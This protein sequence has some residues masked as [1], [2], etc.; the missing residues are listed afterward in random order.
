M[1]DELIGK[2]IAHYRVVEKLGGGGMGVVYKAEDLNL[3]RFVALKFLPADWAQNPQALERF[4]REARAASAL[5]HP[6]I[7]T[8]HEI[9]EYES[10]PFIAMELLEGQTLKRR[11]SAVAAGPR[12]RGDDRRPDIGAHRAPLEL[13]TLLDLAIQIADGLEAAHAKG[14]VH[15]DIKP[16]NIFITTREQAKILDFGLA[17]QTGVGARHGVPLPSRAEENAATIGATASLEPE[18][19]TSPGTAM[20]TVA[21]M[22]PEQARGEELDPRT[23]LFSFGAVLYEMA[24]ARPAFAGNTTAV[25]F[26]AIL[27]SAP[28]S[29]VRLNPEL[30]AKLEEI[31][32]KALE[33]DRRLRYQTASD[34]LADLKRLKR[35]RES[36][37]SAAV[38]AP[39]AAA[40]TATRSASGKWI[41][42]GVIA[43]GLA[44]VGSVLL[45]KHSLAPTL[46]APA[47]SAPTQPAVHTLAVLPFRDLAGAAANESWGIGMAD[48]IISRLAPLQNLAVRPTSS[49]L[50][51]VQAPPD[52]TQVAKDLGVDSILAGTF[53]HN[54][55]VVRVS[56]QLIDPKTQSTRWAGQYDLHG[57]DMLKFQDEVAQK[58]V[59][60]LKVQV[61]EA[62]HASMTSSMTKSPEAY[63]LYLQALYDWNDYL[64]RSRQE[65]LHEGEAALKEAIAKDPSFPQAYAALSRF[66]VIEIANFRPSDGEL[67]AAE[68]AARHALQLDPHSVE[69]LTALGGL[70]GETGKN[71]ESIQ[72][73]RQALSMAPNQEP[74]H[75]LLGYV[76]H[77]AGLDE[78]AEQEYRRCIELNPTALQ[79]HWMH[80]RMLLYLRRTPEAEQELRQVLSRNPDQFKAMAY[81]GE[82][83]YYEGKTRE[84]EPILARA[85]ELAKGT[86][87]GTAPT[88]AAFVYASQGRRDKIDPQILALR[89][90]QTVDGDGAYWGAGIYTLL[91]EKEQALTWLRRAVELGNHNYP[92]FQRDRNFDKLR[93]DR[94]Y[95]RIMEEVRQRWEHYRELFPPQSF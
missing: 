48:A 61:S 4:R 44:L 30:P 24:T 66:Y 80:A 67:A 5:N 91:G 36:G 16:A 93:G 42:I 77:Y 11:L 39:P 63:N 60:G 22:S 32:N 62:E 68:E 19:L 58:V 47:T 84:A 86:G 34:L 3:G 92:W 14:I 87:D 51:Y 74:I 54:G 23:D 46:P 28:V 26:D 64:M 55:S 76:Y 43:F 53:Q 70:Y 35:D 59:E 94:E 69:A 65:I 79:P 29:P 17:K 90:S 6:N 10:R 73:L 45:Y 71:V 31:V 85:V 88:L 40:A 27:N 89:P 95:Q 25:I 75:N 78:Q 41:V 81:L 2:T 7:C 56:V 18:H 21:Y 33:K 9:N 12:F 1:P 38:T 72:T 57:D 83:L 49:V 13:D 20:G 15:R 8:I 37:R 50:K 82:I 52:P